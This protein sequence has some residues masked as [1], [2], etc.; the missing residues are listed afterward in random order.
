[1]TAT[2]RILRLSV[3]AGAIALAACAQLTKVSSGDKT[4]AGK[5]AVHT[6]VAWNQFERNVDVPTWTLDGITVDALQF[7]VGIA[8]GATIAR[9]ASGSEARPLTFHSSMQPADIVALYQGLWTRDGSTFTLDKLSPAA[10]V[11]ANGFRLEYTLV[12]KVDDV[13]LKGV[14]YGA[15]RDGQLFVINYAAPR[16]TFFPK[17]IAKVEELMQSAHVVG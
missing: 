1:M 8:D 16:L 3:L 2:P 17:H 7:Y 5:L 6:D 12:R 15:V 14:A 13:R 10:F 9:S 11:G 4:I